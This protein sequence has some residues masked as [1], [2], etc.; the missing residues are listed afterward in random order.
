[1]EMAIL[2]KNGLTEIV[3]NHLV[4][5]WPAD[6]ILLNKKSSDSCPIAGTCSK[7]GQ[8]DAAGPLN[9]W[10]SLKLCIQY[11]AQSR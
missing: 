8:S 2:G 10:P 1:M 9:P 4:P 6:I 11:L 7:F 3:H 5:T